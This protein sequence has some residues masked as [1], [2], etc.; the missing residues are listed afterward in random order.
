MPSAIPI[1]IRREAHRRVSAVLRCLDMLVPDAT[2]RQ[3]KRLA[4]KILTLADGKDRSMRITEA[5]LSTC[6]PI[7][8]FLP[9]WYA[10]STRAPIFDN[11]AILFS[12]LSHKSSFAVGSPL[13]LRQPLC[14]Q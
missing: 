9:F 6:F 14:F 12:T 11:L 8:V 5:A 1:D 10:K 4:S 7:S 3:R 2:P 13:R